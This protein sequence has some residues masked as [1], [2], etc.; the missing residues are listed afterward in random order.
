MDFRLTSGIRL[1]NMRSRRVE[2]RVDSRVRRVIAEPKTTADHI[3]Q[4]SAVRVY[5][6]EDERRSE[7]PENRGM[8]KE[9]KNQKCE[10]QVKHGGRE[11]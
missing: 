7:K 8:S 3:R 1:R 9:N 11:R 6:E 2:W 5:S 10:D 4:S